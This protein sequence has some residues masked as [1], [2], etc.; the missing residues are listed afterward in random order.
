LGLEW[1]PEIIL[2]KKRS[3]LLPKLGKHFAVPECLQLPSPAVDEVLTVWPSSLWNLNY[4]T[5][6]CFPN[7]GWHLVF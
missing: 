5:T 3:N 4:W 1:D 2:E 6:N 7:S